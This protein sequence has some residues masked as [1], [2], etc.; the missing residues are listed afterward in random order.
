MRVELD[1]GPLL[2]S[3]KRFLNPSVPEVT[4]GSYPFLPLIIKYSEN[5]HM[6]YQNG[7]RTHNS[8]DIYRRTYL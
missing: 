7:P 5:I 3:D 4:E 8:R 1:I 2:T 6:R